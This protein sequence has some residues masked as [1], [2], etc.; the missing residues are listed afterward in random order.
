MRLAP[1]IL[2]ALAACA[3]RPTVATNVRMPDEPETVARELTPDE[4]R[5]VIAAIGQAQPPGYQPRPLE[6]AGP[7]GRWR[8]ASESA[9][10]AVKSCEVARVNERPVPGGIELDLRAIN[11]ERGV[12]RVLGS[13]AEGVTA[14]QV[15]IGPSGNDRALADRIVSAFERELQLRARV[16]RPQ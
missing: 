9:L 12:M 7:R 5:E 6:K 15:E 4:R 13:E 8:D 16:P 2:L 3:P 1:A 10:Q 11:D 14:V